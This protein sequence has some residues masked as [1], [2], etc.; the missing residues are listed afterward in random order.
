MDLVCGRFL[1]F[2]KNRFIRYTY[3]Q[4]NDSQ[5][6]IQNVH[7]KISLGTGALTYLKRASVETP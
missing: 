1:D 6:E 4:L 3:R 2:V 7:I 5:K